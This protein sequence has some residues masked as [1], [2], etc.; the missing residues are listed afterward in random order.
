[1]KIKKENLFFIL[2]VSIILA[3]YSLSAAAEKKSVPIDVI[4]G[5]ETVLKLNKP[6]EQIKQVS[7]ANKEV[8]DIKPLLSFPAAKTVEVVIYGKK[9]GITSLIVWEKDGSKNFFDVVVHRNAR[10]NLKWSGKKPLQVNQI[11]NR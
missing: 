11:V 2:I 7:L 9:P 10:L 8:A 5:K 4:V 1:M 3:S 6:V